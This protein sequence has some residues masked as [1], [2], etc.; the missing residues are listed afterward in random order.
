MDRKVGAH[1][2]RAKQ[3]HHDPDIIDGRLSVFIHKREEQSSH[4]VI[5]PL[6]RYFVAMATVVMASNS[7]GGGQESR[8]LGMC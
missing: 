2:L 5:Q 3:Q 6:L 1:P 4:E 8:N 7:D